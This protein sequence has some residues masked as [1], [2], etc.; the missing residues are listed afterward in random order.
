MS[1]VLAEGSY[2]VVYEAIR[3]DRGVQSRAA[4]KVISIHQD[5]SEFEALRSAGYS[6]DAARRLGYC[7]G[8]Y[9]YDAGKQS[10]ESMQ[11]CLDQEEPCI[12]P[13]LT[14]W[15]GKNAEKRRH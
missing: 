6:E 11:G 12:L 10:F 3:T 7:D 15:E 1:G 2:G 4:I 9:L 13:S 5:K 8:K 14:E